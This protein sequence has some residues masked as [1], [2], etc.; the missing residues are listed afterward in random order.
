MIRINNI[1]LID[2]YIDTVDDV[3][4]VGDKIECIGRDKI[5]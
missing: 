3:L 5:E 4:I 2:K 1:H